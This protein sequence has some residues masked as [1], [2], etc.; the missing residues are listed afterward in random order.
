MKNKADNH[1]A[2]LASENQT[3]FSGSGFYLIVRNY[4]GI[5]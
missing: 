5:S 4:T 2:C 1:A 3:P